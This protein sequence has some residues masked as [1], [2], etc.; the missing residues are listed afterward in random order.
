MQELINN[1]AG[2]EFSVDDLTESDMT[3][4]ADA[5]GKNEVVCIAKYVDD[6]TKRMVMCTS[7]DEVTDVV[8]DMELIF[9]GYDVTPEGHNEPYWRDT[10]DGLYVIYGMDPKDFEK[11]AIDHISPEELE[12]ITC[13]QCVPVDELFSRRATELPRWAL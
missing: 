12:R 2:E 10:S 7:V 4:L 11:L 1:I 5:L 6:E 13:E 3:K 9:A 8:N